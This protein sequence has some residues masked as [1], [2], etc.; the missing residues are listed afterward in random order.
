MRRLSKPLLP[1]AAVA[2]LAGGCGDDDATTGSTSPTA[3]TPAV[4]GDGPVA[5][6]PA[7]TVPPTDAAPP[8]PETI[9]TPPDDGRG[10]RDD[11]EPPAEE[12]IRVP[13][14]FEIRGG[15]LT[16]P[17]ITVPPFLAIEVSVAN[18]DAGERV[19]VVQTPRAQTL[20]VPAGDRTVVRI[21]GQRAGTYPITLDGRAAG[22]L[23]VG[24]EA[25]P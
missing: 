24:G 2:L 11:A 25:G 14:T 17:A 1:L 9:T 7:A 3:P 16:P 18:P 13:A 19:V 4:T 22:Q 6:T 21:P 10:D 20:R 15:A 8:P 23:I 5:S 12:P